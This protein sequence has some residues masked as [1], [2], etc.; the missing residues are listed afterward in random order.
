MGEF[1]I[2]IQSR[3]CSLS[4]TVADHKLTCSHSGMG[5]QSSWGSAS[6]ALTLLEGA[7]QGVGNE[8]ESR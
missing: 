5:F 1:S 6:V 8:E 4:D 7:I 2:S 3:I